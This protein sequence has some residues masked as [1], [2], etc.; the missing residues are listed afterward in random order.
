MECLFA[1]SKLRALSANVNFRYESGELAALLDNADAEVLVFH[2]SLGDAGRG[3]TRPT[4]EAAH[5]HRDRRRRRRQS[6]VPDAI[7]YDDLIAA[8]E[9]LPRIERSGDDLLLWYTGGTTGLP[10]GVLWHQGTL[11]NYGAVYAAGVIDRPVPESVTEAAECAVELLGRDHRP[12]PLLT[13]PLVHATAVHQA[14][15]WFSVGGMVALLRRGPVDGD[16]VCATIERERVTLLSLVGDVILRR[17]VAR[18]RSGR[19]A[20]R[21]LRPLVAPT[22]AQLGCDGERHAQG[23]VAQSGDDELLRLARLE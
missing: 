20:R 17:I 10:K 14:N 2:R 5:A 8:H 4:A 13:T 7:A 6:A 9:P 11:L 1:C 22:R 18:A 16:V 15:T 23:R 21:A 12:V 19:G 3:R